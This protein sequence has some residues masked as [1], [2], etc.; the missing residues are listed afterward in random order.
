MKIGIVSIIKE[1]WGGSEELWA[2]VAREA[3]AAGH[4]V[5][6]SALNC[7]SIHPKTA[8]LISAGAQL[9]FRRGYI[10]PG[11]P[12][13]QRI[14]RKLLNM[15]ANKLQ[16]P[17]HKLFKHRPDVVLYVGTAYSISDDQPLIKALHKW[18]AAFYINCQ[19]N[20]IQRGF[21]SVN[22]DRVRAA[23][24]LAKEVLFVSEENLATA[25][26]HTYSAIPNGSV[27]RN[28]V[29]LA[30]VGL[31]PFPKGDTVHFGMVG[32][33]LADHKGQDLVLDVLHS[34][35]WKGR[36]WHLNIY[37]A[38]PDGDYMRQ[39]T[40]FYGLDS[41]VTFHGR[42]NDIRKVWHDNALMLMPSHQEGM[43]LAVVEAMV[44]GR[45]V[46]AT[47]VGG[48]REW[49]TDGENGFIS[50]GVSVH[51]LA[52]TLER[53]WGKRAEWEQMGLQANAAAMRL[54]DPAPGKTVLNLLLNYNA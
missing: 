48:H 43:P 52:E 1:P 46:L 37:G 53:A 18:P 50:A 28:P 36:N 9:H 8:A 20:S 41:K 31:V 40:T 17:F 27:V 45:P 11:I 23:Y 25:R 33:L 30:N 12:V 19:L 26:R 47:D 3:L 13:W 4:E 7:G 14:G 22:Y 54:Y 21:G 38:G 44:C 42:V 16:N 15:V 24:Q 34:E 29:N 10:K 49:I 35:V 5:H 39:L 51:S 32:M 2:D 6:I